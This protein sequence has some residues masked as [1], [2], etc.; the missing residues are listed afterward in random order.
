MFP[1]R[2]FGIFGLDESSAAMPEETASARGALAVGVATVLPISLF[3]GLTH[4][5]EGQHFLR[6]RIS[7]SMSK[8]ACRRGAEFKFLIDRLLIHF[9]CVHHFF[10]FYLIESFLYFYFARLACF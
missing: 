2:W 1:H 10:I 5:R 3:F 7:H 8:R 6:R 9:L 4:R